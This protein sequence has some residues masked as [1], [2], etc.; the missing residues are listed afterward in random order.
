M[1]ETEGVIQFNYCLAAPSAE[2]PDDLVQPLL[3]WRTVLRRLEL[4]GQAGARYGGLGYGNVSRRVPGAAGGFVIT[5]SQTSGIADA[6]IE[7]L[8]WVRHWDLGRFRVEAEGALPPSSETLT[9]AMLYAKDPQVNWVLHG[10]CPDIWQNAAAVG[11]AAI[12]ADVGYGSPEMA[13]AVATLLRTHCVRPLVFVTLGHEDG[14]FACGGSAEAT[15]GALAAALARAL[16]CRK[17]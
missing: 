17:P 16:A 14:V 1:A 3:A 5:A 6:G 12:D 15:G 11:L 7:H 8:V 2:L 10:H 9:H 4:I 13:A